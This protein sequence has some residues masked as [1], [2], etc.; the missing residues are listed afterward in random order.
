MG[1]I[2]SILLPQRL[3]AG[4]LEQIEAAIRA[5]SSHVKPSDIYHCEFWVSDMR[6]IGGSYVEPGPPDRM[7]R[8][9][10]FVTRMPEVYPD[11]WHLLEPDE[12]AAISAAFGFEPQQQIQ[13]DAMSKGPEINAILAGLV[14]YVAELCDGLVDFG[15]AI[16]PPM[17]E[18]R[19]PE[20]NWADVEPYFLA[21]VKD[22]PGRIVSLLYQPTDQRTW[23]S[24]IADATFLRAWLAHPDFYMIK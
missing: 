4:Q 1:P 9:F 2:A 22:M 23:A 16:Q 3:S 15:G 10:G 7:G 5:I 17:P 6:P 24:H 8:P 19:Y 21:M 14:L 12:V 18:H 11:G 20:A 13:F